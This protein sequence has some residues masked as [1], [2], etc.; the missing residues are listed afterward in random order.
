MTWPSE[1]LTRKVERRPQPIAMIA[2]P[3]INHGV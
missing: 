1:E 3:A 2:V